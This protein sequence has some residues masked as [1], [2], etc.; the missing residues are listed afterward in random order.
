LKTLPISLGNLK[1]V[2]DDSSAC[3]G[4][5]VATEIITAMVPEITK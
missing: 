3:I 5:T 2:I 1:K 4:K